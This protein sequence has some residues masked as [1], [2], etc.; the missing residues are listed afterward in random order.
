MRLRPF[1]SVL[2]ISAFSPSL[3]AATSIDTKDSAILSPMESGP[4]KEA[5]DAFKAGEVKKAVD[6]AKPLADKG[7][8]DALYLMGFAHESGKGA[9]ASRDKALEYYRKAADLKQRDARYRLSFI[10]LAS[11]KKEER[12]EALKTLENAAK[13]DPTVAGRILGEAYLRGLVGEKPD[14]D[15]AISWWQSAAEAGDKPSWV[16]LGSFYEGQFGFP[17]KKDFKK[18]IASFQKA[19]EAGDAGAMA[20]LGSRLLS[21]DKSIQNEKEARK[22][23]Q[24]AIDEKQYAAYLV[25][26]D[27]EE[28]V[29]KDL[30]AALAQYEKGKDVGQVDCILRSADF[31]I[32]GK[33]TEKDLQ[34]GLSLLE[35]AAEAGSGPANYRLAVYN[36]NQEKPD[37]KKGYS[38][39]VAAANT[40]MGEAQNEL[41][42]LYLGGKLG[43]ADVPA[44]VAWLTLG[45]KSGNPQ[46]QNNLGLLY[47]RGAGVEQNFANAGQLYSLSANKGNGPATYSLAR[48]FATGSGTKADLV[49]AWAYAT[50][51]GERG[52]EDSKKLA[53]DLAAK[54]DEK[55]LA[56]AKKALEDIKSGKADAP[57]QTAAPAAPAAT[58]PKAP[59][60]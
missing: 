39:L 52:V 47:E 29:K 14:A 33:G 3:Y 44:G 19:A 7:N 31:Y 58:A 26:G 42:L 55:Q 13:D 24:K 53:A 35:K 4:M 2:L 50:L 28:N 38:F 10:L 60:K 54:L 32:E 23:L 20:S 6:I 34:R 15:K 36:L 1:L 43:V 8:P 59:K 22:W 51:G 45:A 12:E 9:E 57:A 17:E 11:E 40:G 46:A 18:S 21:G 27:Y 16:L 37:I 30:K 25:L 49:K 48:L 5:T 41:G 56:A